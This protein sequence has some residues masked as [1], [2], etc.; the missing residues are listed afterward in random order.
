MYLMKMIFIWNID[1]LYTFAGYGVFSKVEFKAGDFLLKYY[2]D[3]IT[4]EEGLS[5]M[6]RPK[7]ENKFFFYSFK[8]KMGW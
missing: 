8:D 3:K 4:E 2:G 7:A 5:R 6:K 1:V